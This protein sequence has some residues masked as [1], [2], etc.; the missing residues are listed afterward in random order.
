MPEFF[1]DFPP[2]LAIVLGVIIILMV[3]LSMCSSVRSNAK[4]HEYDR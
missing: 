3:V 2:V 4:R 1:E